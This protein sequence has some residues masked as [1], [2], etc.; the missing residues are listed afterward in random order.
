MRRLDVSGPIRGANSMA[1]GADELTMLNF[2]NGLAPEGWSSKKRREVFSLRAHVVEF[3]CCDVGYTATVKAFAP[4]HVDEALLPLHARC[5]E[6]LPKFNLPER[7]AFTAF[8]LHVLFIPRLPLLPSGE[9]S[10]VV[11][12]HPTIAC[13][14]SLL[15]VVSKPTSVLLS[16]SFRVLRA[17]PSLGRTCSVRVTSTPC[18]HPDPLTFSLLLGCQT[19]APMNYDTL[20]TT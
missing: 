17:M 19:F 10:I 18:S 3:E 20:V 13:G 15:R 5:I 14:L 12:R 1:V 7:V 16:S 2:G 8:G 6:L 4:Q 9:V 11:A